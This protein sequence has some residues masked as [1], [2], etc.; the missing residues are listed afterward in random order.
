[1]P[2]FDK[3]LPGFCSGNSQVVLFVEL[4]FYNTV[5]LAGCGKSLPGIE[6]RTSG[7]KAP[8]YFQPLAGTRTTRAK[9]S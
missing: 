3:P 1:L 4:P 9:V 7:A 8:P 5:V 2:P 6:K